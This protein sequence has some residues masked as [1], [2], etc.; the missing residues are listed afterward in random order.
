[1]RCQ[2]KEC[3]KSSENEQDLW[4][5]RHLGWGGTWKKEQDL[6]RERTGKEE[7]AVVFTGGPTWPH[8]P[9]FIHVFS[10]SEHSIPE[11]GTLLCNLGFG[12]LVEILQGLMDDL[13][14]Y[15]FELWIHWTW[16]DFSKN[17][18]P[19]FYNLFWDFIVSFD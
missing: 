9:W 11:T 10:F 2:N 14:L 19:G 17:N 1:M 8:P 12:Y 4:Q 7:S 15:P 13:K 5:R 16:C 6:M 18:Q 3:Y